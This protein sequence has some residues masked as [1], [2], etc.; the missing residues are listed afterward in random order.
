M[1]ILFYSTNSNRYDGEKTNLRT[2]PSFAGQWE[3]LAEKH[4]E[5]HF[6]IATQ[7]P[8]TFLLDVK[9]NEIAQ[10]AKNIE[11]F[12]T[13]DDDEEKIA[14]FLF[15]LNPEIALAASFYVP[16]FDWLT[17]KDALVAENLRKKGI[18]T[19]CHPL[20]AALISF[21]KWQTH[22]FFEKYS[23]PCAKAVYL[24]H[25]LFI[26]GGNRREI[27]S[28]V[29]KN[30][31]FSQIRKL[32]FPAI[33]KDTTGMS[34][35]GMDVVNSFE[36]A[37]A[38]ILSKKTTADRI[39]EEMIKGGQFG[40]EAVRFQKNGKSFVKVLPPFKFSVNRYGITSPKQ[41]VKVGPVFDRE[42]Y[43]LS[44]LE[45]MISSLCEKMNLDGSANFDLVFNE[46]EKKWF[47]LEVNPRL[48][49][50]TTTYAA[51][52]KKSVSEM[53]F[54]IAKENLE[55]DKELKKSETKSE[56]EH[57]SKCKN[58]ENEDLFANACSSEH[59]SPA[60][61]IKF[62]LLSDEKLKKAKSLPFVSIVNQQENLG[63]RQLREKGYCEVI[64]T[65]ETF[66]KLSENLNIL[67]SEFEGE[68]EEIFFNNAMS[69][70]DSL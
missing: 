44:D 48:S 15:S 34:S 22:Q 59:F 50:M 55:S 52:L 35:F 47:V 20:E 11:Y 39:I 25:E 54:E 7:L 63:A 8:G 19:V 12:L 24:H 64:F 17:A 62:P 43:C 45:K 13:E 31:V 40:L 56:T 66:E 28:N 16:P 2:L 21:D 26:N 3:N 42:K 10:K 41:S 69:L 60:M 14:D 51:S 58:A 38:I 57:E 53:L 1:R 9:N 65:A 67:K 33:I 29:Y 18:K 6:L 68:M 61:N 36:E 30:A 37:K 27:K 49:G 70:I 5:H 32:K 4:P 23:F 46:D